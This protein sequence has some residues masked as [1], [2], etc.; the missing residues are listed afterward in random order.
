MRILSRTSFVSRLTQVAPLAFIGALAMGS[1]TGCA[2][3]QEEEID[4]A[5]SAMSLQSAPIANGD[6][7]KIARP[8]GMPLV[9]Q[10][11][12]STG[13]FDEKGKCGPTAVANTLRLYWIDVTPEQADKDG[14]HWII[15][16]MG[17]QIAGYMNNFHPE[18]GCTLEHPDDGGP[19]LRKQLDTG[20]PVMVWFN[21]EG[22]TSHWVV[23]VGHRGTGDKEVAVVMSWGNYYEI[24]FKKFV[25]AWRNVYGIHNPSV[26]CK[27]TTQLLKK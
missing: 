18:L 22:F 12:D 24:N 17:R 8:A 15:G 4:D 27:D 21:T 20:H 11:P 3:E 14:A 19:W 1:A 7:R 13:W 2:S 5:D 23:A 9:Y 6:M 25:E 10:Q 26:V 16:T